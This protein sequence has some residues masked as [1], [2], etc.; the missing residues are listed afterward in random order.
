MS[1]TNEE[2]MAYADGELSAADAA[3][4]EA[5][6]AADPALAE[7]IAAERRLRDSLQGHLNPV[8]EEPV[9]DSLNAM[10]AAAAEEDARADRG[11]VVS[12]AEARAERARKEAGTAEPRRPFLQRWGSGLAIAASLVV[13]VALGTQIASNGPIEQRNGKLVASGTLARGLDAK[14]AATQGETGSLRI[15][16]SFESKAGSYCRVF[17]SRATAGIACKDKSGWVL[18]RTMASSAQQASQYRQ[19][20]SAMSE[21]MAAAQDMAKGAPLDAAQERAAKAKDWMR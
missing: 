18:E 16:T 21:L 1:V 3:R 17:D 6:V 14:L 11:K 7:R 5:A 20:G 19:A 4:V 9:P 8:T 2:L 15:L 10:I 13:G 12:L